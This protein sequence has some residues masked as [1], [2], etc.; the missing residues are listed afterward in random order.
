VIF[1]VAQI[2]KVIALAEN[3]ADALWVVELGL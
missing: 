1:R 2:Q 3:M